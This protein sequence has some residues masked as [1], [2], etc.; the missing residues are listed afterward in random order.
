MTVDQNGVVNADNTP[1]W[2]SSDN[3]ENDD[4]D[5]G[6]WG[7]EQ[8]TP[9]QLAQ[10]LEDLKSKLEAERQ[11][12]DKF[13][14][15]YKSVKKQSSDTS[16]KSSLDPKT[17]NTLAEEFLEKK[18]FIESTPDAKA[19]QM[20]IE[21]LAVAKWL[22]FKEAYKL[23]TFDKLADPNYQASLRANAMWFTGD[24]WGDKKGEVS[25]SRLATPPKFLAEKWGSK[26]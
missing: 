22:S 8:K 4:D 10:E 24:Q 15:R 23:F 18:N 5:K 21:E 7:V 9:E 14:W 25:N 17:F 26:K 19:N 11:R 20:Q 2:S 3:H 12:A 1:E 6:T 13:E 16:N